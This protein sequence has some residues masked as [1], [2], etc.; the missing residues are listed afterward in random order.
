[1]NAYRG[2]STSAASAPTAS[3]S[4]SQTIPVFVEQAVQNTGFKL[5]VLSIVVAEIVFT[6]LVL[7][8]RYIINRFGDN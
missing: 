4:P 5:D 7:L 2:V 8:A 1:M 6:V 3:S